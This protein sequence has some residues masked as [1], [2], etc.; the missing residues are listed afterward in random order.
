MDKDGR[1]NSVDSDQTAPKGAV[2]SGSTT[3]CH[4]VSTLETF[5]NNQKDLVK[6]YVNYVRSPNIFS[7]YGI[8]LHKKKK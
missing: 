5:K 6:F 7:N 4:S 1:A 8:L 2:W 3:V